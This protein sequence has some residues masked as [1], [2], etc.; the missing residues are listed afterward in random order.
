MLKTFLMH[1]S[2]RVCIRS[3]HDSCLIQDF[4]RMRRS[5]FLLSVTIDP[6]A[7][8]P[9]LP[10]TSCDNIAPVGCG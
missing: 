6:T 7:C 8:S 10:V 2:C 5:S 3:F 9:V 1:G 4:D